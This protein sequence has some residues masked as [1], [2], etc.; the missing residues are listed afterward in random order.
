MVREFTEATVE[1]L[2]YGAL[3][4]LA[5]TTVLIHVN[6]NMHSLGSYSI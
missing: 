1:V 4:A 3:L 5:L 6:C 2:M